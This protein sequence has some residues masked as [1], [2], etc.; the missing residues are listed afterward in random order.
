MTAFATHRLKG[1]EPDNLLAFMALLGLLRALEETR[2]KW[3]VRVSWTVDEAP[4]RPALRVPEGVD[5]D[6]VTEAAAEGLDI[7]AERHEFDGLVNLKMS[8]QDAAEQLHKAARNADTDPYRADLWAALVSDAVI[9]NKK[10][11]KPTPLCLLV[12]GQQRFLFL[13]RLA[14]IPKQRAPG[15]NETGKKQVKEALFEPWRRPDNTDSFRWDPNE[16]VRHALRWRAPTD[17][18]EPT[19]YGA[20]MLAA[21]GISAL[22]VV[23]RQRN[24]GQTY[25]A[26]LCGV[27]HPNDHT[28]CFEW[29]IWREPVSLAAIQALL[30]HPHLDR[31][32]TQDALG[33]VERRRCRRISVNRYMNI[34]RAEPYR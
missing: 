32:E 3:R 26:V 31:Q 4:L 5:E 8:S 29:P 13:K 30:S 34:T 19:Q 33:I 28:Q 6:A 9:D 23:P 20:N 15:E 14:S 7:L 10:T 18:K 16:D 1:L 17:D 25:L 27:R 24:N 21:I 12:T 2:P 11:T 22:T